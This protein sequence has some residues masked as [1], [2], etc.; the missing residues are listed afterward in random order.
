MSIQQFLLALRARF[1][2][3]I[4]IVAATVVAAAAVSVFLP[5]SYKATVSLLVDANKDEQSLS[6]SLR[7]L[8]LPQERAN[9]LQTQADIITGE[10][11][12]H[13][14]VKDLKLA[15]MPSRRA[16]FQKEAKG[17]GAI[18]DWLAEGLLKKLK[19]ETSQSNVIQVSFSSA[20]PEFSA[21]VANAFAKAYIATMLELRVEPT[22]QAAAWFDEQLKSLRANLEDTQT[23]LTDYQKK[24][25]IISADERYDVENARL[26]ELS[27]QLVKAQEQAFD[28][29]AREQQARDFL[30]RGAS[31][32]RL[33][34]ILSNVHIQKLKEELAH[35]ES[36]LHELSAQY[37]ANHPAYRRQVSENQGL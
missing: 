1:S 5:K 20:D 33:P 36:K 6:N 7:P 24:Q 30:K 21:Q 2:L 14:V 35:G 3:L 32:D 10:K 23:R 16:A 28:L 37:G 29:D 12:A 15:D 4:L 19:V 13:K 22:R 25:G 31:P 17:L 11:V 9:Y 8:M 26:S 34:D 18:E 27:S